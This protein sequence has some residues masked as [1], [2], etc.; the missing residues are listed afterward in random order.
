VTP[1]AHYAHAALSVLLCAAVARTQSQ[2]P[3]QAPAH[4]QARG[5]QDPTQ[6]PPAV[7]DEL[8][9]LLGRIGPDDA[10]GSA[11]ARLLGKG[12]PAALAA[13]AALAE[14]DPASDAERFAWHLRLLEALGPDAVPALDSLWATSRA[15]EGEPL[16]QLMSCILSVAPFLGAGSNAEIQRVQSRMHP[17]MGDEESEPDQRKRDAETWFR[18][19]QIGTM[20]NLV[21]HADIPVDNLIEEARGRWQ[22]HTFRIE[23]A[24]RL[25]SHSPLRT[26]PQTRT[27]IELLSKRLEEPWSRGPV[28]TGSL[29]YPCGPHDRR[30]LAA[31]LL[32]LQPEPAI[33]QAAHLILLREGWPHEQW[34]A[35]EHLR[36]VREPSQEYQAELRQLAADPTT[37]AKLRLETVTSLGI[38]PALDERSVTL[39]RQLATAQEKALAARANAVLRAIDR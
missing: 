33:A 19:I 14:M 6:D 32:R 11:F 39:L 23:T 15:T 25:L 24:I 18:S 3:A 22:S 36:G 35:L 29:S 17:R 7:D 27:A 34:R 5:T 4:A 2:A 12:E 30:S 13:A 26:E 21:L 9:R 20:N 10:R 31:S 38:L 8:A 28:S 16:R 37:E 1:T